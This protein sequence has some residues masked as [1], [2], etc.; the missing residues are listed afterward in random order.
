MLSLPTVFVAGRRHSRLLY[1]LSFWANTCCPSSLLFVTALVCYSYSWVV[2]VCFT[3]CNFS[4]TNLNFYFKISNLLFKFY[5]LRFTFPFKIRIWC[6]MTLFW[7]K[8]VNY[9]MRSKLTHVTLINENYLNYLEYKKLKFAVG[10]AS[11]SCYRDK[12]YYKNIS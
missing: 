11:L 6:E 2:S 3:V 7:P 12:I 5:D 1:S 9:L 10:R 4:N 8:E